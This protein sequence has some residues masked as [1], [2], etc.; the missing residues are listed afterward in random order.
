MTKNEELAW[1]AGI[2]DGE[3]CVTASYG[4]KNGRRHTRASLVVSIGQS[5]D[6]EI[7]DKFCE[8]VGLG[9]VRG[10]YKKLKPHHLDRYVWN[11]SGSNGHAVMKM[12]RPYLSTPKLSKYDRL[13]EEVV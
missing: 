8:I 3:G 4:G 13:F 1:A 11:A 7:L 9:K 10:P 5:G 6:T 2:F 12:L